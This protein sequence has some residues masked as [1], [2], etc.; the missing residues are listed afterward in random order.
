[1]NEEWKEYPPNTDYLVSTTGRVQGWY[2]NKSRRRELKPDMGNAGYYSCHILIDGRRVNKPVHRIVAETFLP[3]PE[4]LPDVDHIDGN[5]TN[6]NVDNL[7]WM[8]HSENCKRVKGRKIPEGRPVVSIDK[9][10]NIKYHKSLMDAARWIF[11]DDKT[12]EYLR[13][14]CSN[15]RQGIQTNGE[16]YG[17]HWQYYPLDE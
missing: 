7:R 4:G 12:S 10:K 13:N 8:T 14:A 11:D 6:N 3:N 1:M 15:I 2:K 17:Y 9:G 5:K 16:R